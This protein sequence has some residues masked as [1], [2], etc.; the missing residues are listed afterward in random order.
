[1]MKIIFLDVDGVLNNDENLNNDDAL[2]DKLITILAELVK[3]SHARIVLTSSWR[4]F[5]DTIAKIMD[6]FAKFDLTLFSITR[7]GIPYEELK[8]TPW[9][10]IKPCPCY[11]LDDEVCNDR[12]AEIAAWLLEHKDFN[13]EKFVIIDD[14]IDDIK[15]YFPNNY[16]QTNFSTGFTWDN[17]NAALKILE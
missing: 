1:M 9:E 8:N 2:N 10:G 5:P 15:S 6:R 11:D 14:E 13:I 17:L 16:V 4:C 7:E 3:L 12:G